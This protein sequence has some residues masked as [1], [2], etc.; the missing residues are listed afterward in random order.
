MNVKLL[1]PKD[2]GNELPATTMS[3]YFRLLFALAQ[4]ESARPPSDVTQRQCSPRLGL[5]ILE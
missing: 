3:E 2:D 4:A 5:I 1:N